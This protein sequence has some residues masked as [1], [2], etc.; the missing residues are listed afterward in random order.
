MS[1]VECFYMKFHMNLRQKEKVVKGFA[2]HRRIQIME[3]LAQK[4]ES[5]VADI[6]EAL[7][8]NFNTAADHISRLEIGGLL[9]KRND[10]NFVRHRLTNRGLVALK[11]IRMLD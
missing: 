5:S 2:N 10:G 1:V 3:C 9:M 11:F 8:I 6:S 7:K 4:S